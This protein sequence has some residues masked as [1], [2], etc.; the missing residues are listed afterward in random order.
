MNTEPDYEL[1][2]IKFGCRKFRTGLECI[3]KDVRDIAAM[4]FK[5]RSGF[6]PKEAGAQAMLAVRHLEDARMRLGKVMQYLRDGIG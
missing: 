3:E 2:N 6:D 5:S 1:E 4:C